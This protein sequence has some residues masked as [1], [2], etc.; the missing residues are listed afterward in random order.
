MAKSAQQRTLAIKLQDQ[1]EGKPQSA[2]F[3]HA[4]HY[5]NALLWEVLC[6]ADDTLRWSGYED[7][8]SGVGQYRHCKDWGRLEAFAK[9]NYIC[10]RH[11]D[12]KDGQDIRA[13][14]KLC[15]EGSPFEAKVKDVY[16]KV[17]MW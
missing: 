1:R 7:R 13:R 5:L 15:L 10:Q 2:P 4:L 8:T 17:D 12:L 11:V 9:D 14:Y 6:N 3:E 16:G